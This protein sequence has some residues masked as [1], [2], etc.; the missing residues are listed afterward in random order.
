[1]FK[2]FSGLF[3]RKQGMAPA[4]S[5]SQEGTVRLRHLMQL[6]VQLEAKGESFYQDLS[7]KAV[8]AETKKLC[9]KLS[10]D[11]VN[12]RKLLE[13]ILSR[14]VPLQADKDTFT[15]FD[16]QLKAQGIFQQPPSGDASEEEMARYAI[17]Q[18][19]RMAQ[20]YGSFEKD[21]PQEWK[22]GY[23]QRLVMEE[24]SHA[25]QLLDLYPQFKQGR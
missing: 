18:E 19:K 24:E 8:R 23:A 16:S 25:S 3:K 14:W 21:F 13:S 15:Q 12:H 7:R 1:M 22:K 20:F 17:A 9:L 11:E 4:L 6:G 5:Q 10:Q 2:I